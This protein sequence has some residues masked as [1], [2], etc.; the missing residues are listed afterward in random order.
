MPLDV[1]VPIGGLF[2][3]VGCVLLIY[4]VGGIGLGS[5]AGQ[6]NALW[7]AVMAVF[8]LVLG[9]YGLK[10]ERRQRMAGRGETV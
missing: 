1:R 9:Y 10:A 2:L 6:L 4:G 3:A 8:G 5:T 7:G